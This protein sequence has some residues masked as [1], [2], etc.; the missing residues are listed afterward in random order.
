MMRV[1]SPEH[2][3]NVDIR[4]ISPD[5]EIKQGAALIACKPNIYGLIGH[6]LSRDRRSGNIKV[7]FDKTKE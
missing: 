4:T 5:D 7:T 6:C 2:Y 3:L 1:R